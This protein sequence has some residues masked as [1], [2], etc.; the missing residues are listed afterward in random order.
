VIEPLRPVVDAYLLTMLE[1]RTFS[2]KEFF[3]TR[4]GVCRLMPPLPEAMSEMAPRLAKLV[5]P[6]VEQVAQ[7]LSQGQ[8][9][10]AMPLTVP[11]LL[12]QANRSSGRDR[13]RTSPKRNIITPKLEALSAC[14]ECG[15][16]LEDR[17]RQYC[18]ECL[19]VY[20]DA[21]ISSF[22][23]A[24]RAKLQ[25]LRASGVDPSQ[26]GAAAEK[27]RNVMKQRRQEELAWDAVHPDVQT[28][29][30][31]FAREILPGLRDLPLSQI[32]AG[33]GLS[34]QYCSLIRRGLKVPH[35]R[36]WSRLGELVNP[37]QC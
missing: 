24:G 21:Q 34:Q 28:D 14:R 6:V 4:Q 7:R 26:T 29:E 3:E 30:A 15:V 37:D 5:G 8:G 20:R 27:R 10:A 17:S 11:T 16:I 9:T 22:T 35:P 23:N 33:T 36:H 25:D 19:P 13:V 12:T 2:A 32:A 18:E 1:E 31:A